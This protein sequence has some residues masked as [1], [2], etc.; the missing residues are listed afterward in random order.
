MKLK[1]RKWARMT[2]LEIWNTSYGQKK[3]QKSNWQFDFRSLKVGNRPDFLMCR[4]RVTCRWKALDKGYNFGLNLIVI[5]G[6]HTKLWRPKVARVPTLATGQ[7]T[8]W[9]RFSQRGAEYTIW[10]KVVASLESGLWWVLWVWG[11]PWLVLAPK[12][13]QLCTNHFMLVLC[14]L[15]WVMEACQF[16]L[17][18]SWSSSTPP[19]PFQ[20]VESQ[21]TCP[22]F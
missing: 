16:F 5:R 8:I 10:G 7:K 13:F 18:P 6:L 21:A 19:L 9:M 17:I 3:G 11:C 4:W 2:H 22:E 12:V 1:C 14:R 15:V 20:N